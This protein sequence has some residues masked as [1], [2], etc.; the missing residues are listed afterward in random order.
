MSGP[1]LQWQ[2]RTLE[3]RAARSGLHTTASL[4]ADATPVTEGRGLGRVL[5]PVPGSAEPAPTVLVVAPLPGTVARVVL[6]VPRPDPGTGEA[7]ADAAGVLE[8]ATAERHPFDPAPGTLAARLRAFEERHPRLWASRH[9]VSAVVRVLAGLLGLAVLLQ[10]LVR[11]L[12]RWLAGLVP[13]VDLPDLPLP[14]LD[15]PSIPWPDLDLPDLDLP[16]WLAAVLATAEFWV[17][18]LVAVGLAVA[19]VRR[20]RRRSAGRTV[21]GQPSGPGDD[22]VDAHRRP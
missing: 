18:V 16:G 14:D 5:L 13:D 7:D 19:E 1:R 3:V 11:P 10:A 2:G 22:A 9:V 15:L 21:D 8:L 17:P 4:L 12:L 20:K 6:L